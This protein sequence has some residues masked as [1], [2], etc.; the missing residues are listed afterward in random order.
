MQFYINNTHIGVN[1]EISA[2]MMKQIISEILAESR[3]VQ[4]DFGIVEWFVF[5]LQPRY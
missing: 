3:M 1:F 5:E 4:F 2:K